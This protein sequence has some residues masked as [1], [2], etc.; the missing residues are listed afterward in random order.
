MRHARAEEW[1]ALGDAALRAEAFAAA[2]DS[3]RRAVA[4]DS[5]SARA[6]RGSTEAAA[7]MRRLAE[8]SDWLKTMAAAEPANAAVRVELSHVAATLGD[9]DTAIAAARDAVS[10]DPSNAAPLEQLASVFADLG[11]AARLTSAADELIGRFPERNDGRYYRAAAMFLDGRAPEAERATHI[12]LSSD[13][14]HSRGLNLLG[15]ICASRGDRECAR[16]SFMQSLDVNPRDP[17]VYVNLGKLSLEGGDSAEAGEFFGEALTI[18]PADE[19]AM[20]GIADARARTADAKGFH[21]ATTLHSV[22]I[23]TATER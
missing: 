15:V 2:H 5:R 23:Q 17:S 12:L 7:G 10:I 14:R 20:R 3:F 9:A 21:T 19:E 4:L 13:P 11:D 8:E 6:L 1:T 22:D 16:K 18:D